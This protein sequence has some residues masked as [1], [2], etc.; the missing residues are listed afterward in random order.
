MTQDLLHHIFGGVTVARVIDGDII[1]VLR[2]KNGDAR[3]DA[4]TAASDQK[5]FYGSS[6]SGF[7]E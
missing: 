1:A 6:V 2:G 4:A 3:A 5:G 7:P